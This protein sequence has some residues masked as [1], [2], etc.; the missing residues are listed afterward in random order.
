L[1][2]ALAASAAPPLVRLK[3]VR[4]VSTGSVTRI[5]VEATG[6]IQWV[7]DRLENPARLVFDFPRTLPGDG[8]RGIRT[9]PVGDARVKQLRV[10]ETQP[11]RM[12]VVVDLAGPVDFSAEKARR[13]PGVVIQITSPRGLAAQQ[14]KPVRSAEEP[15]VRQP[16]GRAEPQQT[17]P[18]PAPVLEAKRREPTAAEK[19]AAELAARPEAPREPPAQ[20]RAAEPP[21]PMAAALSS[22]R[23]LPPAP[24]PAPASAPVRASPPALRS[25]ESLPPAT[26]ARGSQTLIRALGLKLGRVVLD[27][28]HGGHDHG[29]I[30]RNGLTEKELVLDVAQR[31]GGLLEEQLGVEVIYTRTD[32][33][34][35]PL[36]ER[37]AMAN[38]QRADLFLSIHAN[39][40]PY[41]NA[42]GVETYYLNLST[43]REALDLAARENAS[44]QRSIHELT[45]LIQKITTNE[46]I[47]ESREFASK[48]QIALHGV[49][50]RLNPGA[51]NRGVKKA[52]FVV[53]LG[54]SMPS[55]LTEIGFVS[56]PREEALL[57][58][59]E[60][61]QRIAEGLLLGVKRYA[62]TLSHFQIATKD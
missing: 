19:M 5:T 40:A 16:V 42:S 46:K 28:G 11:G 60:Y 47:A 55:I 50:S 2:A 57:S 24:E 7:A 15:V 21:L 58:K 36:E 45:S 17:E 44:S 3:S 10:A 43:S 39:S 48:V 51:Q 33:T 38:E 31:L 22:A 52:P 23:A 9:I 41:R 61:R 30:G 13:T 37:T 6:E 62:E 26:A 8:K 14:A 20:A 56:N 27:P 59:P 25:L 4:P 32:D 53:L 54:A 34:F 18:E 49:S 1:A 12:R 29:T 35:V